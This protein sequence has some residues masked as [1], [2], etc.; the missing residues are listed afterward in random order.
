MALYLFISL[1][2]INSSGKLL[3]MIDTRPERSFT[4]YFLD[5]LVEFFILVCEFL[6]VIVQL[7]YS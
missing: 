5:E 6:T 2:N 4:I 7:D 1:A 3:Q